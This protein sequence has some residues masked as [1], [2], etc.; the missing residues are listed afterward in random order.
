MMP[1]GGYFAMQKTKKCS[2]CELEYPLT[3]EYFAIKRNNK[4]GFHG[5]CKKCVSEY[6]K[7]YRKENKSY[8][9][10]YQKKWT[11][12]NRE[13]V[14]NYNRE[15]RR[16]RDDWY[17]DYMSSYN[18]RYYQENKD[19]LAEYHKQWREE[20]KEYVRAQG[21]KYYEENK[22]KF[23][24][25]RIGNK[26]RTKEYNKQ[27]RKLNADKCSRLEKRWYRENR[28][29]AICYSKRYYHENKDYYAKHAK[30]YREENKEHLKEY[31][32]Q[33]IEENPNYH[34]EWGKNNRDA[35]RTY[36]QKRRAIKRMLPHTLTIKQWEQIKSDFE[37][38]CAYCGEK[39][40][41]TQEHFVPL[42]KGGE[43]THN[44][45]IPSCG[46][47]NS[48]KGNKDFFKWYPQQETYSKK[49]ENKI[50]EYLNY[51]DEGIQQLALY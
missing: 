13:H 32:N 46:S 6:N 41:L 17:N 27:Y 44:N 39:L 3:T 9:Q 38:E 2:K 31:K 35:T 18:K 14:N 20:N 26:E 7:Q 40:A 12:E 8:Y 51:Q 19:E 22:E 4:D 23:I 5:Q 24:L 34:S 1:M 29:H 50:L 21:I 42:S 28:E 15:Y 33:W 45:I 10:E 11:E 16:G 43:Y 36:S 30:R 25:Y 47:C 49:R 48:S 37:Y